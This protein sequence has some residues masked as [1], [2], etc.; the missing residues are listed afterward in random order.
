MSKKKLADV[1][2]INGD[3]REI[4][5]RL[6]HMG[7]RASILLK[8]PHDPI[9]MEC[10]VGGKGINAQHRWKTTPM[11]A[12]SEDGGCPHCKLDHHIKSDPPEEV[13]EAVLAKAVKAQ[14]KAL[15][16]GNEKARRKTRRFSNN[17][18]VDRYTI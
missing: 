14:H 15:H 1:A 11:Q 13:S 4:R 16:D 3:M 10:A 12:L 2:F 8:G 17:Y 6:S 5:S 18:G 7:Y 9:L